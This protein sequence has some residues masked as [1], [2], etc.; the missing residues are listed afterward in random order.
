[1]GYLGAFSGCKVTAAP[2]S[3]RSLHRSIQNREG[4]ASHFPSSVRKLP[5]VL[6]CLSRLPWV[7]FV[8]TVSQQDEDQYPRGWGGAHAAWSSRH[9]GKTGPLLAG[10]GGDTCGAD[11]QQSLLDEVGE[12]AQCSVMASGLVLGHRGPGEE[13]DHLGN[14]SPPWP[15]VC[16]GPFSQLSS[17]GTDFTE[18]E[19]MSDVQA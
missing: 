16:C 19:Q 4:V 10:R 13:G 15:A 14:G 1:M 11:N 12:S 8:R 5:G 3:I 6:P 7:W 2:Y 18:G 17:D 9:R